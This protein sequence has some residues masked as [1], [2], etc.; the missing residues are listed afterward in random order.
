MVQQTAT[1]ESVSEP[2]LSRL[3]AAERRFARQGLQ[4]GDDKLFLKRI[5]SLNASLRKS[6]S[7]P[8]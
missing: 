4:Y 7:D 2:L 6:T 8:W 5:K 1:A 3:N